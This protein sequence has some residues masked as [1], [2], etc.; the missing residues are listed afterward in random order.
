MEAMKHLTLGSG[1]FF[2]VVT[3]CATFATVMI[4][5]LWINR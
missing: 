4:L 3:I 5:G 1:I 2:S